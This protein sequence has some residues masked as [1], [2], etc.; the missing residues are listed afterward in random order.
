MTQEAVLEAI[1]QR[2]SSGRS[3][4]GTARAVHPLR[5]RSVRGTQHCA[6][7][8]EGAVGGRKSRVRPPPTS[9]Q[10]V[11]GAQRSSHA[12]ASM[13]TSAWVKLCWGEFES[14]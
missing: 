3:L 7:R 13:L 14:G 8:L 11:L 1:E 10:A 12:R 2:T 4:R 9:V 5:G 6:Q